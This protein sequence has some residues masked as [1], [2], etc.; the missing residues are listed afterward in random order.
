MWLQP[1]TLTPSVALLTD[2]SCHVFESD[3]ACIPVGCNF[4]RRG[5]VC[6][7][8]QDGSTTAS[9]KTEVWKNGESWYF[10][11]EA[12]IAAQCEAQP[13]RA[14]T[15][16]WTWT[17]WRPPAIIGFA[18][19]APVSGIALP[20]PSLLCLPQLSVWQW[21]LAIPVP[22]RAPTLVRNFTRCS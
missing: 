21:L 17:A 9:E 4:Q 6:L 7:Q 5:L 12:W 2:G 10:D 1:S 13:Q 15:A 11:Q 19:G 18:P 20:P 22:P 16:P 8:S 14:T 3:K